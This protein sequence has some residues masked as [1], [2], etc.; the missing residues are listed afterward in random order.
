MVD[1][2]Q[3]Y[4]LPDVGVVD[5]GRN[6][7][8]VPVG[9]RLF[10]PE[11]WTSDQD[12]LARIGVPEEMR[13]PRTKPEIALAEI[14]RLMAAH[15]RFG[16]VPADAGYGLSV[17]PSIRRFILMCCID[18]SCHRPWKSAQ[19]FKPR[20]SFDRSQN[21]PERKHLE[22][23]PLASRH[24]RSIDRALRGPAHSDC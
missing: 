8:S 20:H 1:A 14:N 3:M 21:D 10:L 11:S 2:R 16:I 5:A 12:R 22:K 18:L 19:A 17:F 24:E 7:V 6:A 23:G 13:L 15:V 9:F 4:Q